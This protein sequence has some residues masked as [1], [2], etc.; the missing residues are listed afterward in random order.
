M[1]RDSNCSSQRLSPNTASPAQPGYSHTASSAS[2]QVSYLRLKSLQVY[3]RLFFFFPLP[4]QRVFPEHWTQTIM[5]T[6]LRF[7]PLTAFNHRWS[8]I[9]KL[10]F[11]HTTG[12]RLQGTQ[13]PLPVCLC[14]RTPPRLSPNQNK[15]A[16]SS[17]RG[18]ERADE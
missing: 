15:A 14:L 2:S 9:W 11:M 4:I 16:S 18:N 6:L 17:T 7:I 8:S 10:L 12:T 5:Q 1:L 3:R 13:I